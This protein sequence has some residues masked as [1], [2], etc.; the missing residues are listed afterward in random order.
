MKRAIIIFATVFLF[1]FAISIASA[2]DSI[3]TVD[4]SDSPNDK[5]TI[6]G[7]NA[8]I[9]AI[10]NRDTSELNIYKTSN[11]NNI[12]EMFSGHGYENN[13]TFPDLDDDSYTVSIE[14]IYGLNSAVKSI[15]FLNVNAPYLVFDSET[16]QNGSVINIEN[17]TLRAHTNRDTNNFNIYLIDSSGN[18]LNPFSSEGGRSLGGDVNNL[19]DGQY[20]FFAQAELQKNE[21]CDYGS[22][23]TL[24]T[25]PNT[26]QST[27]ESRIIYIDSHA[28]RLDGLLI[29]PSIRNQTNTESVLYNLTFN[30]SESAN[31]RILLKNGNTSILFDQNLTNENS[32]SFITSNLAIGNYSITLIARDKA[33]HPYK[34]ELG[35]FIVTQAAIAPNSGNENNGNGGGGNGGGGSTGQIFEPV[36]NNNTIVPENLSGAPGAPAEEPTADKGGFFNTITGAVIGALKKPGIRIGL[37]F[38]AVLLALFVVF[39]MKDY[40]TRKEAEREGKNN[41]NKESEKN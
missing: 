1:A 9:S 3:F 28:P 11:T 34:S 13:V 37:Y 39:N 10:A 15:S 27:T 35:N 26:I 8:N 38:I 7:G 4:F 31:V 30:L 32:L 36:S 20:S 16:P 25:I 33:G 21:F 17:V 5:S 2:G 24:T 29:S 23:Q 19:E 40:F 22:I 14:G 6:C 18:V 12:V 41:K